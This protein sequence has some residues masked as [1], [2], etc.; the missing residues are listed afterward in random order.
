MDFSLEDLPRK[1]QFV[2]RGKNHRFLQMLL[3]SK[4]QHDFVDFQKKRIHIIFGSLAAKVPLT[5]TR[6]TFSPASS[7][8]NRPW[9]ALFFLSYSFLPLHIRK[10]SSGTHS[11]YKEFG[12]GFRLTVGWPTTEPCKSGLWPFVVPNFP[13]FF[14]FAS[15]LSNSNPVGFPLMGWWGSRSE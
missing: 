10:E 11:N 14:K 6:A 3:W 8:L 1:S 15:L 5:L 2:R 7:H 9:H 4:P 12:N 13:A